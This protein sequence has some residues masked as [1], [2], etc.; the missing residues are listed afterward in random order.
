MFGPYYNKEEKRV[1]E[2]KRLLKLADMLEADAANEKGLKFDMR[3]WGSRAKDVSGNRNFEAT[4]D[5][6][7]KNEVAV[8]C[9]TAGCAIGLACLSGSFKRA[10]L[11]YSVSDG[12]VTPTYNGLRNFYA[13]EAFFGL[14]YRDAVDLFLPESYR[15]RRGA[16]AELTVARRIRKFVKDHSEASYA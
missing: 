16:K 11:S 1:M 2:D 3:T 8:S 7:R 4:S 15:T 9:D 10:G 14:D 12:Y 6:K 5:F 13:V